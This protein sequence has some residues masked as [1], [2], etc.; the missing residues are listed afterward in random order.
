MQLLTLYTSLVPAFRVQTLRQGYALWVW[1]LGGAGVVLD[2]VSIAVYPWFTDLAPLLGMCGNVVL[3]CMVLQ[4]V[5][6]VGPLTS[7]E[8]ARDRVF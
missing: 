1:L 6:C 3:A 4:L 5:L 8:G 7:V 2:V